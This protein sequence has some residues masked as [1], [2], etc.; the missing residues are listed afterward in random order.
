MKNFLVLIW[1]FA[2]CFA[3]SLRAND[4]FPDRT[5]VPEWFHQFEPADINTL[6]KQYRLTDYGAINDSTILQTDK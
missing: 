5:P 6:G 4:M 1:L 2:V 3:T